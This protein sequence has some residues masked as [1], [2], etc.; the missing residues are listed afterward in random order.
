LN[1]MKKSLILTIYCSLILNVFIAH[2]Q[3]HQLTVMAGSKVTSTIENISHPIVI[4]DDSGT[5]NNHANASGPGKTEKGIWETTF[6]ENGSIPVSASKKL[7]RIIFTVNGP[8]GL[9]KYD[10]DNSFEST[11]GAEGWVKKF[12][13]IIGKPSVRTLTEPGGADDKK[14]AA[15]SKTDNVWNSDLP[16]YDPSLFWNGLTIAIP[17]TLKLEKNAEWNIEFALDNGT[18]RNDF[19]IIDISK[20]NL[21]VKIKSKV[22]FNGI[23]KGSLNANGAPAGISLGLQKKEKTFEGVVSV[24]PKSML[25]LSGAFQIE[26]VSVLNINGSGSEQKAYST[27]IISNSVSK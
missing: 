23:D 10:S 25:I 26:T 21:K 27:T 5:G 22:I 19:I 15:I 17:A 8:E 7:K 16:T 14:N 18:V 2:S 13:Q 9:E 12:I 24:D 4:G 6:S 3:D 20:D 11:N 1:A